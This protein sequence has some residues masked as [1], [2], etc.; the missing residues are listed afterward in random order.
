[1]EPP[2]LGDK[3]LSNKINKTRV[4]NSANTPYSTPQS[5]DLVH[6]GFPIWIILRHLSDD[7]ILKVHLT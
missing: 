3:F 6:L 4:S 2:I 7:L 1:M 5:I